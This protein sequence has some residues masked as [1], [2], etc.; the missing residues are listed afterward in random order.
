VNQTS[1][2][3]ANRL[4]DSS[5]QYID[6]E[7]ATAKF[8]DQLRSRGDQA[9]RT[10]KLDDF[11]ACDDAAEGIAMWFDRP[12]SLQDDKDEIARS[13]NRAVA[14]LDDLLNRQ[15]S[16]IIHD[17]AFQRL[18]SAWRGIDLLCKVL[19]DELDPTGPVTKIKLLNVSWA[20]LNDDFENSATIEQSVIFDRVYEQEFGMAGGEPFGILIGN[21]EIRSDTSEFDDF[22]VLEKMAGVAASAFSPFITNASPQLL[23]LSDFREL[24]I[25]SDFEFLDRAH[26]M[27]WVNL[28]NKEDARFIG[29]CLPHILMR[30]PYG[31]RPDYGLAERYERSSRTTTRLNTFCFVEESRGTDSSKYLWGGAAFAYATVVIRSFCRT[32]WVTDIRGVERDRSGGGLVTELPIEFHHADRRLAKPPMD[33][34]ITDELEKELS[35]YGFIP[36][37]ACH[38]TPFAAF[39]SGRSIQRSKN[40]SD[41]LATINAKLSSMLHHMLCVSRFAHYLKK[42]G[43]DMLG[44]QKD[45]EEI[46]SELGRWIGEY[47]LNQ[48]SASLEDKSRFPLFDADIQVYPVR[49]K[50]GEYKAVLDLQPHYE[51]ENVSA[52]IRLMTDL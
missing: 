6:Q 3:A 40:Y 46:E 25:V 48:P 27:R 13:L 15:L 7:A 12:L 21:Y 42:I 50:S 28:V 41:A 32:G 38:S 47:T 18:E 26:D 8:F 5:S 37:C 10:F 23:E 44:K 34:V 35:E 29:L 43:R 51:I 1:P 4:E 52:K 14:F 39:F 9:S 19:R 33:A 49:G 45:P 31:D 17:P 30:L 22:W 24:D 16:K 20:E 2:G 11:L 36:L